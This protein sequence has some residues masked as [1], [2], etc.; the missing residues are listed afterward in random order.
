MDVTRRQEVIQRGGVRVQGDVLKSP[1]DPQAS[2]LIRRNIADVV[3]LVENSALLRSVKTVDAVDQTRFAGA[4]GADDGQYFARC[5]IET[6][7]LQGLDATEIQA[8]LIDGEQCRRFAH[9]QKLVFQETIPQA[10]CA[11]IM[12]QQVMNEGSFGDMARKTRALA[13]VGMPGSGKTTCAQIL[14]DAGYP[15]FRF[16]TI[17]I[18]EIERRGWPV[19]PAHERQIREELRH[20]EGM[21]VMAQRALPILQGIVK[22]RGCVVMDGLYS[23]SEYRYLRE[24][25]DGELALL[26]IAAPRKLRHQRLSNR[27]DRPLSRREAEQRDWQEVE[28][29]EKSAPIALAE[30]TIVNDGS[31][32]E[33]SQRLKRVLAC[34]GLEP[35]NARDL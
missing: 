2:A 30:H 15:T 3:S 22:E 1:R 14:R 13:I 27:T 12:S 31:V 33:L 18:D 20:T 21:A 5:Y 11:L 28:A 8:D 35:K 32:A 16:G 9:F 17:V 24:A 23:F 19:T 34:L 7:V 6:D 4:I 26:A 29:L 25:L 10:A